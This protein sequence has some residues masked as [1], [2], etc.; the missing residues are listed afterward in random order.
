MSPSTLA[1][2]SK[3]AHVCGANQDPHKSHERRSV[4]DPV[5]ANELRALPRT[6]V[7]YR[8]RGL[9]TLYTLRATFRHVF[10]F[11]S[12]FVSW[13][14]CVIC[15]EVDDGVILTRSD[16]KTLKLVA[17]NQDAYDTCPGERCG[18]LT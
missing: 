2:T 16:V 1:D 5:V 10:R 7:R 12:P 14:L 6:E 9:E 3:P 18:G 17:F 15:V 13:T 8:R 11:H 4:P